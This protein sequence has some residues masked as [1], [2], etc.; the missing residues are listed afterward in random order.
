M[1]ERL[2]TSSHRIIFIEISGG[3]WQKPQ[4]IPVE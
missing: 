4:K 3:G 2:Y 1:K